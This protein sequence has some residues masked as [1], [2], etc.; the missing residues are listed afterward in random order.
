MNDF[1]QNSYN[2]AIARC[3]EMHVATNDGAGSQ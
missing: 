2:D 3:D 1:K